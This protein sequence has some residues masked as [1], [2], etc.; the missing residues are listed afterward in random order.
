MQVNLKVKA[1]L[2][3]VK[4]AWLDRGEFILAQLQRNASE[5]LCFG[6]QKR[7]AWR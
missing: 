1:L 2:F 7:I 5:F 3:P 4:A 6:D